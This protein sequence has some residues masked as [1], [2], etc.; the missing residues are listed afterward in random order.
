MDHDLGSH[1]ATDNGL[2]SS[3]FA[4]RQISVK[5]EPFPLEDAEDDGLAAGPAAARAAHAPGTEV[6]LIDLDF[7]AREGR[8]ALALFGDS[9]PDFEKDRR[10]GLAS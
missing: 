8:C 5:T 4:V 7:A 2:Q 6:T 9:L 10:D 1:A 3:L